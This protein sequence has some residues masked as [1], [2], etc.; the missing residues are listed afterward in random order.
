MTE[1]GVRRKPAVR[2]DGRL[3]R[4]GRVVVQHARLM[5][6]LATLLTIGAAILGTQAN[7]KLQDG[8]LVPSGAPSARAAS[9]IDRDFGGQANLVLLVTARHGTID[10]PAVS[11]AAA[12]ISRTVARQPGIRLL[13]TRWN[14]SDPALRSQGGREGLI[15]A[16]VEGSAQQALQRSKRLV[17][18]LTGPAQA[19]PQI[20][21]VAAGGI[22]GTDVAISDQLSTDLR[23]AELIAVPLTLM[24]L[25]FALGSIVAALIPLAMGVLSIIATL[26]ILSLLGSSTAV[27][28]Y[29]LNL[30][31][32]LGLGLSIDYSLL[33][34][35]RYREELRAGLAPSDAVVRTIQT[36]GRTI[37]YSAVAVGAT[38]AVLAVFPLFFLRSFAYAGVAVVTFSAVSGIVLLPALL[39]VLGSR[40]G[41]VAKP[42]RWHSA[43]EGDASKFW[44]KIASLATA[45]PWKVVVAGTLFLLVLALP[46]IHVKFASPDSSVLPVSN[47]ARQVDATLGSTF[48]LNPDDQIDVVIPNA[49]DGRS[50]LRFSEKV[51]QLAD[52]RN[53]DSAAG[54]FRSGSRIGPPASSHSYVHLNPSFEL[55]TVVTTSASDLAAQ[56]TVVDQIRALHAPGKVTALVSGPAAQ[57]VDQQQALGRA[58]PLALVIIVLVTFAVLFLFT[59]S[60][61]LPLE[62]V[63]LNALGLLAVLGLVVWIFQD[64]HLASVLGF[65]PGPLSIT[66]P[67]LMFSVLFGL[68]M[69]YEVFLLARIKEGHDRGLPNSTAIVHGVARTGRI[70]STA[71]VILAATFFAFGTSRISFI[72][73][74]GIGTGIAVILD[75]TL[76]RGCLLPAMMRVTGEATWWAPA[77]LPRSSARHDRTRTSSPQTPA[78]GLESV[79]AV[80]SLITRRS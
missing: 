57:L 75:A 19:D 80:N 60:I 41:N 45:N 67:I 36:A 21:T 72:Q 38:L 50:L 69:D 47:S 30:T 58:L 56:T 12:N 37:L 54:A 24:L 4:L 73:M 28:I 62:A 22:E 3:E 15:L 63:L 64:G 65:T 32:L 68:S 71:A 8:G 31:T 18:E 14:S 5:L 66:M 76:V 29:A 78:V 20:I 49:S 43:A 59:R 74:F 25:V 23:H 55:L 26:A 77:W 2:S 6:L 42:R 35:S 61:L 40:V 1:R 51:S 53:V 46:F 13:A 34:V 27:S 9:I 33:M 70:I 44:G 17:A 52:V 39:V 79:S 48:G 7:S 16:D 10:N 11:A